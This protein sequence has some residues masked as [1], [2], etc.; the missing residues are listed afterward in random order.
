[1]AQQTPPSSRI[2]RRRGSS[3][4]LSAAGGSLALVTLRGMVCEGLSFYRPTDANLGRFLVARK[5]D[6]P[7]AAEQWRRTIAWRKKN[8]I[9]RFRRDAV[10]PVGWKHTELLSGDQVVDGIEMHP[11]GRLIAKDENERHVRST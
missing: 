9:A 8:D 3:G 1:M 2:A 6:I 7:A 11:E 4:S 10:G 5:G